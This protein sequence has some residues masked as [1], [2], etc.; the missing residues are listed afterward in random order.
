MYKETNLL[1]SIQ[2]QPSIRGLADEPF[3]ERAFLISMNMETEIWKDI[4]NYEGLY[5]AS[6]FGRIKGL[7]RMLKFNDKGKMKLWKG[8]I[9]TGTTYICGYDY[10]ILCKEGKTKLCAVSRLVASSFHPNP[11]NL[12]QVNHKDENI[13]NNRADN[14]EWCTHLYNNR[15]GTRGLRISITL[16]GR[17][18][19]QGEDQAGSKLK[20][21][22]VIEIF[23]SKLS[24][25]TLADK[26]DVTKTTI[27]YIKKK[28][29]WKH[30]TI[31]L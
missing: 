3:E 2:L 12:P 14:L 18:G 31:N 21:E 30:L 15:Y 9:L 16:T 13:K 8:K 27:S 10:K 29:C 17:K 6:N 23:Y 1:P 26:Y 7:D 19:K 20:N 24:L 22:Q 4:P 5:Q 25:K 28:K 11:L